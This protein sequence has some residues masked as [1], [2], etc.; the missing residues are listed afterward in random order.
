MTKTNGV[1]NTALVTL[2]G[3]IVLYTLFHFAGGRI[4]NRN[5][6]DFNLD[7]RDNLEV[8]VDAERSR[9]ESAELDMIQNDLD[10]TDLGTLPQ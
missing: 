7:V 4:K 8:Q 3:L 1:R 5:S 2:L 9:Q 10:T 6:N